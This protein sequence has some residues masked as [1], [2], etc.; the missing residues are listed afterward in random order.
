MS[1]TARERLECCIRNALTLKQNYTQLY[2][3]YI[4]QKLLEKSVSAAKKELY[5]NTAYNIYS[6]RYD[7]KFKR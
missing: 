2:N 7:I 6:G 1:S 3:G 5:Y 4:G